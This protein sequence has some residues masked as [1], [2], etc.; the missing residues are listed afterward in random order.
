M[1]Q[2]MKAEIT[3]EVL[4]REVP[5][6]HAMPKRGTEIEVDSPLAGATTGGC[7][8][9]YR[10]VF[11]AKRAL[12]DELGM[13]LGDLP[14]WMREE[15]DAA[16]GEGLEKERVLKIARFVGGFVRQAV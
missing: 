11:E 2:G 14:E 10:N 13:N 16:L 6:L 7:P 5:N 15:I 12:A 3:P 1:A 8:Y 4:H 9:E